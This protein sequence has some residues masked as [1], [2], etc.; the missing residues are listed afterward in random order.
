MSTM[1][2][3]VNWMHG[4]EAAGVLACLLVAYILALDRRNA[5]SC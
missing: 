2:P 4:A 1:R 3:K 5:T